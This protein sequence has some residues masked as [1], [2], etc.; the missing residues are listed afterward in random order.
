M[1]IPPNTAPRMPPTSP[2]ERR[3]YG[4]DGEVGW[5]GVR[6]PT[7]ALRWE[8]GFGGPGAAV[9][10]P[11]TGSANQSRRDCPSQVECEKTEDPSRRHQEPASIRV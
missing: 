6:L 1:E 11:R 5:S 3:E 8:L 10:R 4:G 7:W 2:S 9:V